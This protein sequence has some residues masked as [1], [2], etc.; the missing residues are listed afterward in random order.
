ME[1]TQASRQWATRPFDERF[2]DL[3]ELHAKVAHQK[4]MSR[5]P[6]V[7]SKSIFVEPHQSDPKFGIEVVGPNG[8][9]TTPTNWS[10]GQLATLSGAPAGYLRTL[11]APIVSD[12]MN[13]GLRFK[14][15]IE[16]VGLLLTKT[17]QGTELRAATGPRYG[18][19]WNEEIVA[20]LIAKYGDGRTGKFRVPGEFG[21][22]VE[23]NRANTTIY[24]SDRNIFV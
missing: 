24:G 15:E 19:I 10:F 23:I 3:H 8:G 20:A 16:D 6:V 18:R 5:A 2:L 9:R 22:Q 11:P 1:L 14:R 7:A 21:Q 4:D 12:C 13:Y 17:P